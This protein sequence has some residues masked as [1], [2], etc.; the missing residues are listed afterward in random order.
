MGNTLA[1]ATNSDVT[2]FAYFLILLSY[3]VVFVA[4][5]AFFE[6]RLNTLHRHHVEKVQPVG[7]EGL[8][9]MDRQLK[10]FVRALFV[11]GYIVS[12]AIIVIFF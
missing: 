12:V 4:L 9:Y 10:L 1:Q 7:V 3:S 8:K 5:W 6:M 11:L 2:L